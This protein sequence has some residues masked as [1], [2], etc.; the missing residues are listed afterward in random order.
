MPRHAQVSGIGLSLAL[1]FGCAPRDS[2][3]T[4]P[5][6]STP[7]QTQHRGPGFVGVNGRQ[8]TLDGSPHRVVGTNFWAAMNL[9]STGPGGDRARLDRELDRLAGLGINNVRIIAASE[10]PNGVPNRVNPALMTAPGEYDDAVLTGLDYALDACAKR[11]IRAVMVLNNFWEWSGGMPQYVSWAEGTP[12]AHA[13][14]VEF[15]VYTA[16]ASRFYDCAQCQTW[17]RDHIQML[18]TR[19]NS[20]N[21]RTYRDDPTI[22]AWE[23]AN[24]PRLY[25]DAWV[26]DTAAFIR[27]LDPNHLIT[28]G[29]EGE[30]GGPFHSTH[31]GENIDYATVH[32]WPQNWNWY[33]P[34]KPASLSPAIA[35][36][37]E[38]LQKH[39]VAGKDLGK[40]VVLE[41]F[42]LGR[43][44]GTGRDPFDP[45][46]TTDHR[47]AVYDALFQAVERS[48]AEGGALQGT[49]FWAWGGEARPPN[50]WIGDPPHEPGGWYSVYDRDATTL[51][52]IRTHATR[53]G[54]ASAV[55]AGQP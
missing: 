25:P 20:V 32:I 50:P 34:K 49:A 2:G 27:G 10:G 26:D 12:I 16:Y 18:V 35:T 8:F 31:D 6:A 47:D 41:E 23:L 42:G 14:E 21:G 9:G 40:P 11:G 38:Y 13:W 53:M 51:K 15:E 36:A 43:D 1:A 5:N 44:H 55:A 19:T 30:I 48:V 3:P 37:L 45:Q 28:A 17:Y 46:A 7:A 52:R 33:D 29:S 54:T 39:R 22:F 24:E 4:E